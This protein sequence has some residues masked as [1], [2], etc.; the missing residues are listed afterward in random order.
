MRLHFLFSQRLRFFPSIIDRRDLPLQPEDIFER[1]NQDPE[2]V[3]KRPLLSGD[4]PKAKLEELLEK[5]RPQ[6]A[7]VRA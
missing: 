5:R 1:L 7:Q 6:Y 4:D 3:A 2:Q